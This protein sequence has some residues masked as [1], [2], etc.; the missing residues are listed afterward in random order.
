M[1]ST[2]NSA[3]N[4][5]VGDLQ[6]QSLGS[7]YCE[8][9]SQCNDQQEDIVKILVDFLGEFLLFLS[10]IIEHEQFNSQFQLQQMVD[11][12]ERIHQLRSTI[13]T[14]TNN[15]NKHM[16]NS[17]MLDIPSISLILHELACFIHS[18]TKEQQQIGTIVNHSQM[19]TFTQLLDRLETMIKPCTDS[20]CLNGN[21]QVG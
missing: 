6:Q 16:T 15:I 8:H 7:M 2:N 13:L 10:S 17:A 19:T 4:D 20:I 9:T 14:Q 3:W 11:V 21:S 12:A 18:L 1:S 5:D